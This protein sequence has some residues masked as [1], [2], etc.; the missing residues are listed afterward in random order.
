MKAVIELLLGAVICAV[1]I[2][3]FWVVFSLVPMAEGQQCLDG[4]SPYCQP[5]LTPN[6]YQ[7]N[8][9]AERIEMA[10]EIMAG[11]LA[12]PRRYTND[13][14]ETWITEDADYA[15]AAINYADALIAELKKRQ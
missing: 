11:M 5:S 2:F 3:A 14:G 4:Q 13:D 9:D 1:A 8:W 15:V 12:G 7:P 10:S 6:N